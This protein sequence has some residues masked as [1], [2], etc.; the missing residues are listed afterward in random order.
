MTKE[1]LDERLAE[2]WEACSPKPWAKW[3]RY[4]AALR[5]KHGVTDA[6]EIVTKEGG[7]HGR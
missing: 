6:A 2:I 1:Q 3:D 7:Q 5:A 4:V